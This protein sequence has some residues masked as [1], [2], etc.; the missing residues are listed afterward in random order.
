MGIL[1]GGVSDNN[2]LL[3]QP[4]AEPVMWIVSSNNCLAVE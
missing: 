3:K 1:T 4:T 2:V